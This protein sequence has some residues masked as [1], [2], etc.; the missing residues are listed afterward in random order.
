M[1]FNLSHPAL[2]SVPT[3][4]VPSYVAQIVLLV[5]VPSE[6]SVAVP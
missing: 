2:Y 1:Q 6:V 3:F 4:H 5:S